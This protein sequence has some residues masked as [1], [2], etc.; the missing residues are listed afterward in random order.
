MGDVDGLADTERIAELDRLKEAGY[1]HGQAKAIYALAYGHTI[2]TLP[3][4]A[5]TMLEIVL[6]GMWD[7][8][9]RESQAHELLNGSRAWKA[10]DAPEKSC[11]LWTLNN[12]TPQL[13]AHVNPG[14]TIVIV[15]AP[16]KVDK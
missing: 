12:D 3:Q 14:D 1:S 6:R 13:F 16:R 5:R 2:F 15:R 4:W 8:Q 7:A 9:A 11:G 10:L